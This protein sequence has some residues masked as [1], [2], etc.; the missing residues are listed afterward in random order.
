[1]GYQPTL[2]TE[3]GELQERI[4]ST[5]K[6]AITSMQA[7]YVPADDYTDPAPVATFAH[8]DATIALER[9]IAEKAIFPAVYPLASTSRILDPRIVGEEHYNTAREVQRLLQRYKDLQDIIAILGIDELSED[10]KLVVSR[11]RKIERFFS[12]PMSVAEQFTGRA[13]RYVPL[14]ETVNGFREILDGK[15]DDLP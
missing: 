12:Q 2:G 13:G 5:H 14:R 3:M 7:V 4:V 8:L 10:D 11:A 1:V 6:G 15:C 9:S